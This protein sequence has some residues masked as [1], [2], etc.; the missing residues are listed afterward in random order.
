MD[1]KRDVEILPRNKPANFHFLYLDKDLALIY[2]CQMCNGAITGGVDYF[3]Q[4][5]SRTP[6]PDW[7]K[8]SE[9]EK[10]M[11][12]RKLDVKMENTFNYACPTEFSGIKSGIIDYNL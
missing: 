1:P 8:V 2:A 12:K 5:L 7:E 9:V 6:Y 11:E 3:A 10:E 4:V